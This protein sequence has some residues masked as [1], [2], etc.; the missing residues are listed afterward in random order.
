[1]R[2]PWK[3]VGLAGVAGVAATGVVVARRRRAQRDY[4]PDEVRERLHRR[5]EEAGGSSLAPDGGSSGERA[6]DDPA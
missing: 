4:T 5:L 2:V 3:L 6:A 1:M